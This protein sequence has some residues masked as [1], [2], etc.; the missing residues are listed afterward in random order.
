MK[1]TLTLLLLLS[2]S[3]AFALTPAFAPAADHGMGSSLRAQPASAQD[4]R[5]GL[6]QSADFVSRLSS[7]SV[8]SLGLAPQTLACATCCAFRGADLC[9]H[10]TAACQS[11][12]RGAS[13]LSGVIVHTFKETVHW[14]ALPLRIFRAGLERAPLPSMVTDSPGYHIQPAHRSARAGRFAR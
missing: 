6:Q 1:T 7:L 9:G 13:N 4:E 2:A 3:L 14:L 5:D 12:C 10:I 11:F 8:L